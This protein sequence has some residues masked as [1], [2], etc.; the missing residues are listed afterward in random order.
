MDEIKKMTKKEIN[1][2]IEVRFK[3][4]FYKKMRRKQ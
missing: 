3:N 1:E 2:F 4:E